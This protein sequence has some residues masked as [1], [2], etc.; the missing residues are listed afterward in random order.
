VGLLPLPDLIVW[1]FFLLALAMLAGV[2]RY[3]FFWQARTVPF[4]PENRPL[5]LAHRGAPHQ[6]PEN[7]LPAFQVAF[8][9]G[10]DGI[11]LDV[12]QTVDGE[13]IV[14]HDHDLE[15]VTEGVGYVW[16]TPYDKIVKLNAAHRWEGA[17]PPTPIPRLEEVLAILPE[18][19]LINI[20]MKTRRG[21]NPGLEKR[22]VELV[23]RYRLVQRTI[24]SSFDP[25]SLIRVRRLEPDIA[26]GLIWWIHSPW[27]L[28]KLV[29]ASSLHPDLLH[30]H[31]EV[32]TPDMVVKAH[33]RGMKVNVWTI[34]NR[35]M[36]EYLQSIG[37]DG[38]FTDFPELAS[39][40]KLRS[41]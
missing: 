18:D 7:T 19:M 36:I 39:M 5:F 12:M 41:R 26:I 10:V 14:K 25:F 11:E 35:P 23:R 15:R 24:I 8:D 38:I 21:K 37:V 9:A 22:V 4:Y 33:R 40:E 16:E 17:F 6:A 30:P 27:I 1:L 29:F 34:N 31:A 2:V 13:L 20:E 3:L 32:V 28:R